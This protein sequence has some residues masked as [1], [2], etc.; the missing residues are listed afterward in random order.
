MLERQAE[1]LIADVPEDPDLWT[2]QHL[3]AI[4][5]AADLRR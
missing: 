2:P 4:S 5:K 3:A 1:R